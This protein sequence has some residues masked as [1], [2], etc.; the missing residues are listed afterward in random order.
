VLAEEV[1][2]T[3]KCFSGHRHFH[4]KVK[5]NDEKDDGKILFVAY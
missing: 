2:S 4:H 5:Y 3:D 1:F